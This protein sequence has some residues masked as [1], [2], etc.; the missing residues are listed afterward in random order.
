MLEWHFILHNLPESSVYKGGVYH[1]RLSFPERYPFSPP[2]LTML[3]PS[4]RLEI[5]QRLCLSMT[6]FHPENWN[7]AWTVE[8]IL[9]GLISFMVDERD[10]TGLGVVA[11]SPET[12]RRLAA[13]SREFNL[14]N[15]EFREIFPEFTCEGASSASSVPPNVSLEEEEQGATVCNEREEVQAPSSMSLH[16]VTKGTVFDVDREAEAAAEID[17]NSG[18]EHIPS[19]SEAHNVAVEEQEAE[20]CW[21]CREDGSSEPL[22]RPCACRGSMDGVHASCVEAWVNHHRSRAIGAE[23]PKCSVCGQTYSGTERRPGVAGFVQHLCA[24]F[25]KQA[26]RS[27]ILVA[28]L[29]CYWLG[30]QEDWVVI[31]VRVPLLAI[32]ST[33]FFHKALVLVLSLPWSHPP[34]PIACCRWFYMDDARAVA[35]HIAEFVSILIIAGLWYFY[36]QIEWYYVAPLGCLALA[37]LFTT[38]IRQGSQACSIRTLRYVALILLSPIIMLVFVINLG[39]QDPRRLADPTDGLLHMF[40][41]ILTIPLCWFSRSNAPVLIIWAV[42][43]LVLLI[44]I[45]DKFAIKKVIWKEGRIWWIFMQLA[46]LS[47]YV[48]NLL[49]G[50]SEGFF[51]EQSSLVVFFASILWLVLCCT[52]SI[53]VNW[54]LC[55]RQYRTWQN[56]NG[57]FTL[58]HTISPVPPNP[59]GAPT[60]GAPPAIRPGAAFVGGDAEV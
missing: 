30:A 42:H 47:A 1:G 27:A 43:C 8:S 52:L 28:I 50:F 60:A 6:D 51:V 13:A 15:P 56:R 12:R 58:N 49:H 7:P 14:G 37:P 45:A 38:L 16:R 2:S 17:G 4:G 24:D 3:T 29:V 34:P 35:V 48:A 18:D 40:V 23:L 9:V 44:G 22:I 25:W 21:I 26:I 20:E 11:A 46:I 54:G 31:W 36:G 53:S 55:I 59:V 19:R 5:N 57:S 33:F 10:P 39:C 32:A 41:A